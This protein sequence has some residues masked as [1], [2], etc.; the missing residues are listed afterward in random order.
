MPAMALLDRD[1]V[2]GAPRFYMAAK[3][4]KIKAHMGAEVTMRICTISDLK[5]TNL[6]PENLGIQNP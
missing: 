2:Y 4:A 1:G 5:L 3:K 6:K